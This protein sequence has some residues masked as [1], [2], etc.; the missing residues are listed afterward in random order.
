MHHGQTA[1]STASATFSMRTTDSELDGDNGTTMLVLAFYDR[2][3]Q[4][5]SKVVA[6]LSQTTSAAAAS[7][8]DIPGDGSEYSMSRLKI[9]VCRGIRSTGPITSVFKATKESQQ[10]RRAR[11]PDSRLT[12]CAPMVK[13]FQC[14]VTTHVLSRTIFFDAVQ[15]AVCVAF[16]E[17]VPGTRCCMLDRM[18]GYCTAYGDGQTVVALRQSSRAADCTPSKDPMDAT[19]AD[20][21]IEVNK[22]TTPTETTRTTTVSSSSS[23]SS[24]SNSMPPTQTNAA[25]R[26]T[27]MAR[28]TPASI[29]AAPTRTGRTEAIATTVTPAPHTNVQRTTTTIAASTVAAGTSV[30]SASESTPVVARAGSTTPRLPSTATDEEEPSYRN[31]FLVVC[32]ELAA[33]AVCADKSVRLGRVSLNSATR[34]ACTEFCVSVPGTRCCALNVGRASCSAFGTVGVMADNRNFFYAANCF[35][36]AT[37]PVETTT[38]AGDDRAAASAA[39]TTASSMAPADSSGT[40][41]TAERGCTD[42]HAGSLQ[43]ADKEGDGCFKYEQ[44][45]WCK[46][47]DDGSYYG[48]GWQEGDTFAKYAN[49]AGMDASEACCA[50]GGGFAQGGDKMCR[51]HQDCGTTD[52]A[53]EL[54]P[55]IIAVTEA[56]LVL[57]ETLTSFQVQIRVETMHTPLVVK[58]KLF[59]LD[60]DGKGGINVGKGRV[61]VE[62][63]IL[64]EPEY[65]M[66]SSFNES[67][68][69]ADGGR[70]ST[71]FFESYAEN[72]TSNEYGYYDQDV[73]GGHAGRRFAYSA[74][75]ELVVGIK[76]PLER[77][78]EYVLK[79]QSWPFGISGTANVARVLTKGADFGPIAVVPP[80]TPSS[81]NI[82][83]ETPTTFTTFTTF[84]TATTA[85]ATATATTPLAVSATAST[86]TSTGTFSTATASINSGTVTESETKATITTAPTIASTTTTTTTTSSTPPFPRSRTS[87]ASTMGTTTL[88]TT[89]ASPTTVPATKTLEVGYEPSGGTTPR[90]FMACN[91]LVMQSYCQE[92]STL[93]ARSYLFKLTHA[94]C[95]SFCSSVD[96]TKCC[97]L[98][99]ATSYCNAYSVGGVI[100][101]PKKSTRSA[102]CIASGG[103]AEPTVED[104]STTTIATTTAALGPGACPES[105]LAHFSTPRTGKAAGAKSESVMKRFIADNVGACATECLLYTTSHQ[106]GGNCTMFQF[107]PSGGTKFCELVN[108]E[109]AADTNSLILNKY[110]TTFK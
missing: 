76:V 20:A 37:W 83:P 45:L 24:S 74:H 94:A 89:A 10:E 105:S 59:K 22:P 61:I 71:T 14:S 1:P 97:S 12:S 42:I 85:T 84:T 101:G 56:P 51:D 41:S 99:K 55:E 25:G 107:R 49:A 27:S 63:G 44:F 78:A 57:T 48:P 52:I 58:A 16:C 65:R 47:Q 64:N 35:S 33:R 104:R 38:S 17:T 68:T 93:L 100:T 96:G 72:E 108:L 98:D 109:E 31:A 18:T 90:M 15:N 60:A 26:F 69:S 54:P 21:V 62:A 73:V 30:A 23:S 80:F 50:C 103:K 95:M 7:L 4:Q 81:S 91:E 110:T 34:E 92:T 66:P 88:S 5:R 2:R 32:D 53:E 8:R 13:Q 67:E 29:S 46:R 36:K 102:N 28:A 79:V 11:Q 70:A 40:T 87:E 3:Q 86:T 75:A 43:W 6:I 106:N 77:S 9:L 82:A 39:S 19:D